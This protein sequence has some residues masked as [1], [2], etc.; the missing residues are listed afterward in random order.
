M[1]CLLASWMDFFLR[2]FF[3]LYFSSFPPNVFFASCPQGFFWLKMR[4]VLAIA[5]IEPS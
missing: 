2:F 3:P 4:R 1:L 5:L